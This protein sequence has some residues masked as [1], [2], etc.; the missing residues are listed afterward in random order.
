MSGTSKLRWAHYE[1]VYQPALHIP[2]EEIT[3]AE[4]P[5]GYSAVYL[6][7][8]DSTVVVAEEDLSP[9]DPQDTAKVSHPAAALGVATAQQILDGFQADLDDSSAG[10]PVDLQR[11]REDDA[12]GHSHYSLLERDEDVAPR[13]GRSSSS[14]SSDRARRQE[15]KKKRREAKKAA[16]AVVKR[17]REE[18]LSVPTVRRRGSDDDDDENDSEGDSDDAE[19]LLAAEAIE[20]KYKQ[21]R[22]RGTADGSRDAGATRG[23]SRPKKEREDHSLTALEAELFSDEEF[24]DESDGGGAAGRYAT[25]ASRRHKHGLRTGN[26]MNQALSAL[27]VTRAVPDIP[28]LS[29]SCPYAYPYLM[30]IDYEY[31][32]LA[33]EAVKEGLLLTKQESEIVRDIDTELRRKAA[34]RMYL[35]AVLE[36]RVQRQQESGESTGATNEVDGLAEAIRKLDAPPSIADMVRRLI[37][38]Q[39]PAFTAAFD[40]HATARAR[41]AVQRRS[42]TFQDTSVITLLDQLRAFSAAPREDGAEVMRKYIQ[43]RRQ[44]EEMKLNMRGLSKTGFYAVPKPLE[45]WKRGRDMMLLV[46]AGAE[47]QKVRPTSYIS[48]TYS[49]MR[50]RMRSHAEKC[51]DRMA[52]AARDGASFLDPNSF[53]GASMAHPISSS[54]TATLPLSAQHHFIE[55]QQKSRLNASNAVQRREAFFQF[56]KLR[57]DTE[58]PVTLETVPLSAGFAADSTLVPEVLG[59]VGATALA[60]SRATSVS[61]GS[62]DASVQT[63][64]GVSVSYSTHSVALSSYPYLFDHEPRTRRPHHRGG[65]RGSVSGITSDAEGASAAT[66][67]A[68][69]LASA[70]SENA[71]DVKTNKHR[72]AGKRGA[73]GAA[74]QNGTATA[75]HASSDWRSNAKRSIMEQLTLYRRGKHGKPA[76]LNDEQCREMCRLLLD[77]AMRAEAERQGLSLAVQSNNI[78]SPFTKLTEQRLKKSVDHYLERQMQQGTLFATKTSSGVGVLGAPTAGVLGTG[79]VLQQGILPMNSDSAVLQ[80]DAAVEARQRAVADTPIYED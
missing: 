43:Q 55:H 3:E 29:T 77:R 1:G 17:E 61:R 65:S 13:H 25:D 24:E 4:L 69:S 7:G 75:S 70:Y 57:C 28:G 53:A 26:R 18:M 42:R 79:A 9:Y 58:A 5:P 27:N 23:K 67:R 38:K 80:Y 50:E 32:Q 2:A 51:F 37:S 33:Q 54:A 20:H 72:P 64:G 39:V 59:S 22:G 47:A 35:Q 15:E 21:E 71:E 60:G 10:N 34:E 14:S 73:A 48:Q 66:S 12:G 45:K 56:H 36:Q 52:V 30:E 40:R 68:T 62:E 44:H 8:L 46:N 78:A 41:R 19:H 11:Q 76:L 49:K 31:R 16:K 74:S 63:E 6:L